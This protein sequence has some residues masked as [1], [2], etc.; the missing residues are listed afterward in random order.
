MITAIKNTITSI[1]QGDA[2]LI[3]TVK[4]IWWA[5]PWLCSHLRGC[6]CSW[7]IYK[8]KEVIKSKIGTVVILASHE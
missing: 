4:T 3:V 6:C 7:Y 5:L 8:D 2:L 1:P